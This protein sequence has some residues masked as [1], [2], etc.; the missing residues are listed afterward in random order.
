MAGLESWKPYHA[1]DGSDGK[2]GSIRIPAFNPNASSGEI[3]WQL[4][5]S[6]SHFIRWLL[7]AAQGE[8]DVS[9]K[10]SGRLGEDVESMA[11]CLTQMGV[12]IE[13][14]SGE[15][16]V[17]GVGVHGFKRP[18]SVLNCGNSGTALRLL[19]VAAARLDYPVM[20]DGDR[21]LRKRHS[22]TLLHILE[23][24][25]GEVSHG[26]GLE[27]LPYY[28]RGPI[29]SGEVTLEVSRSSQP[30]SALLLSMPALSGDVRVNLSGEGVSRRHAQLS[31]DLAELTGSANKMDWRPYIS[32][33]PWEV[34]CPATVEIPSDRSLELFA[35]LFSLVHGVEVDVVNRPSD[36]DSLGAEI[37]VDI[38]SEG[39]QTI[40]LR[41]AN[42]LISPLAAILALG[43]G[44]QITEAGHARHK[45]SNRIEKTVALLGRFGI[46]AVAEE[47]GIS[48][49]G[50]QRISAPRGVVNTEGDHRLWMTAACLASKV[51]ATLSHPNCFRVSDPDFLGKIGM[52]SD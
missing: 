27:S 44:G 42:D 40:S 28:V 23:Y 21:T 13:R 50:G 35:I 24:L 30:L 38:Q 10:F 15:W 4:A 5:P 2:G 11:R 49:A 46:E 31:F 6:K 22:E 25:G 18:V 47:A 48:V 9:L 41:D 8:A 29:Q 1:L 16:T 7:L 37:L 32:L 51:G 52:G 19:T 20:L 14:H 43:A 3:Q 39:P 17:H 26:T 34:N 33:T 36:E 12:R 45:E